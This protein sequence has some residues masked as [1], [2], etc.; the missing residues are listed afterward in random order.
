MTRRCVLA[1]LGAGV[2][3]GALGACRLPGSG[4][5]VQGDDGRAAA[6][7]VGR[8]APDF[9]LPTLEGSRL[10]LSSLRGKPV[11]V[12]FFA[13]WC[14][15]CL[16]ELPEIQQATLRHRHHNLIALLVDVQEDVPTVEEFA[17]RLS[18]RSPMTPIVLDQSGEVAV[19]RYRVRALPTSVFIDRQG[20]IRAIHLGP[21]SGPQ[22]ERYV[23]A[24]V[25]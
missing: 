18:L 16:A 5:K 25:S 23:S 10:S 12:N 15:P 14:G 8:R 1:L 3:G 7:V 22:L 21:V 4:Q 13:S 19:G 9:T 24:I 17:N 2:M 11:L 20:I 6:P